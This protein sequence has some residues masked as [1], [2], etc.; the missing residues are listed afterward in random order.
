MVMET[1]EMADIAAQENKGNSAEPEGTQCTRERWTQNVLFSNTVDGNKNPT[2][3]M[4]WSNGVDIKWQNGPL[5]F[6]Y[7]KM[8]PKNE[9]NGAFV[10]DVILH[11]IQRM[12]F[13]QENPDGSRAKFASREGACALTHLEEALMW[14]QKRHDNRVKRQVQGEHKA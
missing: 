10:E 14:L 9:P 11:C 13:F 8:Q 1:N 5:F 2:G 12:R 4:S 6:D 7:E 3:G